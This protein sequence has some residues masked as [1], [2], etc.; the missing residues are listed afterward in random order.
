FGT[1]LP[2]SAVFHAPTVAQMAAL[3]GDEC[4]QTSLPR[5]IEYNAGGG[6]PRLVWVHG[7]PL[8]RALAQAMG[9]DQPV[10]SVTL[11]R[12]G[13]D[14]LGPSPSVAEIAGCIARIIR[15]VQPSGPYWIGGYCASGI[16]A[17]ELA[18]QL[19]AEGEDVRTLIMVHSPDP[20]QL[21]EARP[22][23]IGVHRLRR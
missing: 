5:T 21:R 14:R 13:L 6:R 17:Y 9:T 15:S 10:P 11:D 18:S 8:G 19:I 12:D 23:D 16:L 7:G 3:L 2:I 1:R 22:M 4:R 20:R